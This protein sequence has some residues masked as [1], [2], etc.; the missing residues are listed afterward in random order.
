MFKEKLAYYFSAGL[1]AG[2]LLLIIEVI[3]HFLFLTNFLS[4]VKEKLIFLATS[5]FL[6]VGMLLLSTIFVVIALM[7][8]AIN[9]TFDRLGY[10]ETRF[11][12]IM[13]A[14]PISAVVIFVAQNYPYLWKDALTKIFS[15]VGEYFLGINFGTKTTFLFST[16]A[17]FSLVF[18][19]I[20]LKDQGIELLKKHQAKFF[21]PSLICFIL[22]AL[23]YWANTRLYV[24]RYGYSFHRPLIL[25]ILFISFIFGLL[26]TIRSPR[27][28]LYSALALLFFI[29]TPLGYQFYK[30]NAVKS[31][32]WH[33]GGLTKAYIAF[34]QNLTDFDR[35]GFSP[36]FG[37]GDKDNF[38]PNSN[39]L[40][41]EIPNNSYDENGFG[42]DFKIK[43]C[44][45]DK[46][47]KKLPSNELAL[48]K[49][50]IFITVDCLRADHL[51]VYGYGR[52]TSPNL[53][54]FAS[55]AAVF[56][57]AYSL[58]TNTG[59][60]FSGIARSN[61]GP[62]IF[63]DEIMTMAEI[64]SQQ[65]YLTTAITAPPTKKWL[66]KD[67]WTSYKNIMLKGL[68]N[69]VN[70]GKEYWDSSQL[71]DK[72]IAYLEENKE[73]PFYLWVHYDDLHAK[74][75]KYLRYGE[76]DYGSSLMDIYDSNIAYTDKHIGRLLDY[77][78]SSGLLEESIVAISA[79]HG[80]EFGEH[81][82]FFHGGRPCRVQTHIP[83]ILWYPGINH[84]ETDV[85]VSSID[86][87]PTLLKTV[88]L[89][90]PKEYR[91]IDLREVL[92]GNSKRRK[93]IVETPRNIPESRSFAWALVEGEW[94]F[95]YDIKGNTFELYNTSL[96]PNEYNNVIDQ[97]PEQ[98][99]KMIAE[100]GHWLD[101][102]SMKKG[103]RHWERF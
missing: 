24:G 56:H 67:R 73:Q 55:K 96:D 95:I 78:R 48:A 7:G 44:K 98:A 17:T 16:I 89:S 77:L 90:T 41:V 68:Q 33:R 52:P 5:S 64:L 58:G 54:L 43:S 37:G 14:I 51:S 28:Y 84:Q 70:D 13:T 27:F 26:V 94:R 86:I 23:M 2:T 38:N 85:P 20:W 79:D 36:F 50:I 53:D 29:I 88:G 63:N 93:I 49:N 99:E 60:T 87:N 82:Q 74:G 65:K 81:G 47:H 39:P 76:Q 21:Y 101:R 72:T 22:L 8:E 46:H 75:E 66:G 40:A 32:V 11:R 34:A 10:K 80:E 1:I 69:I 59:H 12:T 15:G 102:Q 19:I 92:N 42:G 103:Y 3:D 25:T 83:L 9:K 57:N 4:S 97:N 62:G 45:N 61:Y 71:T 30:F 35:D 100:F 18:F 91:G 6:P 31:L